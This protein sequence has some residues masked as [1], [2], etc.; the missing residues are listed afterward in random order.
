[1]NKTKVFCSVIAMCVCIIGFAQK[2]TDS[3]KVETLEEV[4]ITD[5]RFNL[6]KENS[7]K[8]I[9]KIT[10][11]DLE[12]QRGQSIAEI[13]GRTAGVEINGVRSNAGQNLNYF[14]RGGRNRQVL[15]LINGVQITDPSSISND[16][17][18]RLLNA[19]QVES[20]E[21]LK[22]A[23]STLYGTGAAT[24]VINI[25]LK[26]AS[27]KPFNL[28]LNSMLGTNQT[29]NENDYAVEDFR[30]SVSVD[31]SLN[32]LNYL[33]SFGQQ[34]TD[35]LSAVANGTESDAFNSYSAN[36]NMGYTFN[37]KFK[38]N[39]YASLDRFKADF[40]DS[41]MLEDA[42]NKSLSTQERLGISSELKYKKGSVTV[43]AAY[44]DLEREIV[45]D[46]PSI[47]NAESI[48]VDG[49]NRYNFNDT[50]YTVLG[51][52]YQSSQMESATIPFGETGF[53]Q[54]INP[55]TAQ[56][57]I[58]DPY[59]N[60]VYVSDFGLNVNG[61]LRVNNHSEYGS[62]LV[63]SLNPSFRFDLD[64]GYFKSLTSY[65]TA[66]I[67]PSL[68]Q[69]FEPS[70]GNPDL[71]PEENRTIEIGTELV[72]T[73]LGSFSL[74]Y[75]NR[76][77]T[78]FINFIDTG[79]FVFQYQNV[80]KTFTASGL[81]FVTQFKVGKA[82]DF[83][84]NATYTSL[85]EDLGLRIPELKVN[86]RLDYRLNPKTALGLSYQYNDERDDL[87]FNNQTFEND[88]IA[89]ESYGLLD[90]YISQ[91]LLENKMT[92]FAN[93]TNILNENYQELFGFATRGR[94]INLGF[95]LRL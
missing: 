56:F 3:L 24:A 27:K 78:N 7:G 80:N 20:I 42:D 46:F 60:V 22:G 65:S 54:S 50:F 21:I 38:I 43:N 33:A 41:F 29:A 89:L 35:G 32:K 4:V 28:N 92:V 15:I 40:D 63:Y 13:I 19:A 49:F 8:V 53:S 1:M 69:L 30:N 52:N 76:K 16:Y 71:Q 34:F 23:S 66:Y 9:T 61:G 68:Y 26:D 74:V 10:S 82:L 48:V 57:N 72:I 36:L 47:F 25:K 59:F 31:G 83:N 73:D 85:N 70:F 81:E 87:V 5:S 12:K 51:I 58:I 62:H 39:T 88:I 11:K 79:N 91:K 37:S 64:I 45:S 18:L 14:I 6:N 84:L 94:G 77:E 44:T 17:D 2:Q 95:N 86:T 67:T 90:F 55:E 75:F 93:V